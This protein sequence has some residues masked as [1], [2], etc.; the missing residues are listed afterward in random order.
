MIAE[1]Q[2]K[3]CNVP[4][5]G[6]SSYLECIDGFSGHWTDVNA[7]L[8][9][10][11]ILPAG[12][13]TLANL[14]TDRATLAA[15]IAQLE[16]AINAREGH[17]TDRDNKK[18][19]MRERMRQLSAFVKGLLPDSVYAGQVPKQI[20][21]GANMGL[22]IVAMDDCAHLWTTINS[23]PP[24]GF[25][26][27]LLLQGG[28]TA[29]NFATDVAALKTTFTA[30]TQSDHDVSRELEEREFTYQKIRTQLAKYGPA[31]Q[32]SLPADHPL[33]LSIPRI[34]P[35]PGHTPD[36]SVLSGV[37]NPATLKADLSWTESLD[38]DLA[39]YPIRRDGSD[40]YNTNTEQVVATLPPGTLSF[41]TNAGLTV[42]GSTMGFKV[43]VKLTT[44]NEKGSNAI[45]LTHADDGS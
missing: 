37:W 13:Y 7:L 42:P 14:L 24:A 20:P 27:P 15:D 5:T 10:D 36:A 3:G 17:S 35:L 9:P 16:G 19:P 25:T 38:P 33:V 12:G 6:P 18:G 22:W 30:L 41:S 8:T 4:F 2:L 31:V 43:Y 1:R 32:G 11:L 45:T 23:T 40:P 44:G 29:A 28:Y 21:F 39:G 26:P 34:A